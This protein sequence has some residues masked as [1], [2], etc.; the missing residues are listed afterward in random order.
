[1]AGRGVFIVLLVTAIGLLVLKNGFADSSGSSTSTATTVKPAP[2]TTHPVT[3]APPVTQP[4]KV[5]VANG[6][7]V[8]GA[9]GK[10]TTYLKG[11]H[12][13]TVPPTDATRKDYP[14][15]VVYYTNGYQAQAGTVAQLLGGV[16]VAGPVPTPSPV[17]SM[18]GANVLVVVGKTSPPL[19]Q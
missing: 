11:K 18:G 13:E 4:Y 1:M 19:P 14:A 2:S 12:V 16:K 6:S 3:T 17:K 10:V 5:I 9:A 15:T 7:G 8:A